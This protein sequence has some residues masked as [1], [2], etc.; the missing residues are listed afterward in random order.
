MPRRIW[1]VSSSRRR[2]D[3]DRLE[4]PLQRAVL[5]DV[6]AVLGRG[7]GADAL[8][9]AARQRR[10]QDVGGVEA[11]LGRAGAHQGVQLVDEDDDVVALGQLAHDRLQP[12][13]ELAAVLGAGHDQ[14]DVERQ[15]ALVGQVHGH[16]ALHDLVG[17]PL[18]Q[19]RLAD[20]RLADQHGVVAGAAAQDLDDAR[21]ARRRARPAG[22]GCRAPR[23]R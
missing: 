19:R 7:G 2:R 17:Q 12:L 5:L 10:L 8:D 22:R 13:L 21:P 23:P 15:D 14:R 18:D 11:A 3:L 6:L 9:L 4:A 1:I 16:V 20:A